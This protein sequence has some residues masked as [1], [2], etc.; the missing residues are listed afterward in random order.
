M[1]SLAPGSKNVLWA[2]LRETHT[3]GAKL[4]MICMYLER[5]LHRSTGSSMWP[6]L[7]ATS[8][9]L[10]Q[11]QRPP[12]VL[13]RQWL[14]WWE[15]LH[16]NKGSYDFSDI[17]VPH[18]TMTAKHPEDSARFYQREYVGAT[19]QQLVLILRHLSAVMRHWECFQLSMRFCLLSVWC[20]GSVG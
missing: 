11:R 1:N 20:I 10:P 3:S 19:Q 15:L 18:E 9:S 5:K 4:S 16:G 12:V 14:Q 7:H 6:V 8:I 2:S 13:P 17:C